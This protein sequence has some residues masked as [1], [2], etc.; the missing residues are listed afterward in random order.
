[1]LAFGKLLKNLTQFNPCIEVLVDNDLLRVCETLLKGN[2]KEKE[3]LDDIS[4]MGEI[5]E[6]N[7][8]ILT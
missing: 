5:L 8:K 3:V 6:K 4:Y 1:L 7:I 2:I